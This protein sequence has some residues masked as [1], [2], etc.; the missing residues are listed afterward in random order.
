VSAIQELVVLI[1]AFA[2]AA[3]AGAASDSEGA[4]YD[5]EIAVSLVPEEGAAEVILTVSQTSAALKGLDF[6]APAER[7]SNFRGDGRIET[8]DGRV[9]WQVPA[10]G[11]S[12]RYR[13][14]IDRLR[15]ERYDARLT[16]EWGV[17]RLDQLVPPARTRTS[18][19]AQASAVLSFSGPPGWRFETPYGP[20]S[21]SRHTVT[22]ERRFPRPVGWAAAGKLGIRRDLIAGRP[23]AVAAPVGEGFRRQDT[24]AFLRWTLPAL[25]AVFP[26]FPERLLIVGCGQDMWR[27]GLSGPASLYVHP[28]RPLI[29][30]NGTSTLIHELVHVALESVPSASDD[31][32]V[33][34]LAEYYS[35]ELLRRTGGISQ[36][37]FDAALDWLE[38]W[39]EREGGRLS[40]PSTGA[41]T[42]YAVLRLKE[43]A[44]LL[45]QRSMSM[46]D[47]VAALRGSGSFTSASL[48]RFLDDNQIVFEPF[49]P[50][51]QER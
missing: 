37:R 33:E 21:E 10:A 35:L 9:R 32:L 50:E 8:D 24:L 6:N 29:S 19:K 12:L 36:D 25:I 23:V 30:G 15:G 51:N 4:G 42:A 22:S 26:E 45:A 38:D 3:C 40:E 5:L 1:L 13:T 41:D 47:A 31:W 44:A 48:N 14:T 28:D 16:P 18:P 7:F 27:G 11:G 49:Q 17:F 39:A 34:G 46:D 2:L 43:L 20:T